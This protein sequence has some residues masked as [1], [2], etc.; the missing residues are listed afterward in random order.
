M[1]TTRFTIQ[2]VIV[3]DANGNNEVKTYFIK[4]NHMPVKGY[5]VQDVNEEQNLELFKK[6]LSTILTM[7]GDRGFFLRIFVDFMLMTLEDFKNMKAAD[8]KY[9]H[10]IAFVCDLAN[11]KNLKDWVGVYD[12]DFSKFVAN[13]CYNYYLDVDWELFQE[14]GSVCF[15]YYRLGTDYQK[16][17]FTHQSQEVLFVHK[18]K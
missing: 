12:E 11:H 8:P 17:W 18:M 16:Q 1:K 10:F 15:A 5:F 2:D 3:T 6:G 7:K 4:C 14:Y 13:L 9:C